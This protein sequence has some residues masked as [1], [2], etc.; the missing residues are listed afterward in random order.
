MEKVLQKEKSSNKDTCRL[1]D[2]RWDKYVIFHF[3]NK[4]RVILKKK[5]NSWEKRVCWKACGLWSLK[6]LVSLLFHHLEEG[7]FCFPIC[8]MRTQFLLD[9]KDLMPSPKWTRVDPSYYM[10][11][12]A[13]R[14]LCVPFSRILATASPSPCFTDEETEAERDYGRPGSHYRWPHEDVLDQNSS[15]RGAQCLPVAI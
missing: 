6:A 14:A 11:S 1:N 2:L 15:S 8:E 5:K 13:P 12:N 7:F 10:P 4:R 3:R 9:Y